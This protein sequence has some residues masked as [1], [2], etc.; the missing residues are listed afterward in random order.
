M[1]RRALGFFQPI[2]LPSLLAIYPSLF[3]YS[4]N[5]T[6]ILLALY[7][8]WLVTKLSDVRS[9]GHWKNAILVLSLLVTFNIIKIIPAEIQKL[10]ISSA[11][12]FET[13]DESLAEVENPPDIYFIVFD[14]FSGFEPM[15]E[16]W[17]YRE[18]DEF[19]QFLKNKGF[20]SLKKATASRNQPFTY[21]QHD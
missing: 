14:E 8:A 17:Q 20:L 21:W 11:N 10:D 12:T 15:R 18:V 19:T 9:R 7:S 5:A 16:Y 3:H 6:I 13:Q 2:L 4:N 1:T